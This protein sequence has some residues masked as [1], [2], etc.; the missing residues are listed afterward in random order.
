MRI[1][2]GTVATLT[3]VTVGLVVAV[4]RAGSTKVTP[5]AFEGKS[6]QEAAAALL[7]LGESLAGKG[8]WELIGVG[9]VY[10]LSGDKEKGQAY[11]DRATSR[12]SGVSE[13]RR[14]AKVYGEAGEYDKA[15]AALE[16]AVAAKEDDTALSELA[17]MY[18]LAG[19]RQKAEE[20]FR[21]SLAKDAND[22]WNT[23]DMAGSYLG[24]RPHF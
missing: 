18:N 9:R 1:S 16:K 2:R 17:A 24:V 5:S 7:S 22:T 11:F 8:S 6:P 13:W 20:A 14:I 12:E 23:I 4:A 19:D 3:L 21:R 10:Y 15:A